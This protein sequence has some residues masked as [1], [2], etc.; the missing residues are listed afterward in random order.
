M[1]KNHYNKKKIYLSFISTISCIINESDKTNINE[2]Y[3]EYSKIYDDLVNIIGKI[4]KYISNFLKTEEST[5][6]T[7]QYL[8]KNCLEKMYKEAKKCYDQLLN[9]NDKNKIHYENIENQKEEVNIAFIN[10]KN[11]IGEVEFIN[12]ISK[13]FLFYNTQSKFIVISK[14]RKYIIEKETNELNYIYRL[15]SKIC[16][17]NKYVEDYFK[18]NKE[19]IY[20]E[21]IKETKNECVK[22]NENDDIIL[23][24][25]F[26]TQQISDFNQLLQNYSNVNEINS[27]YSLDNENSNEEINFLTTFDND[28]S[29]SNR[30]LL[31]SYE[32]FSDKFLDSLMKNEY[33]M[34]NKILH[35][36][37]KTERILIFFNEKLIIFNKYQ[38]DF[39][40]ESENE[41]LFFE[42]VDNCNVKKIDFESRVL[43]FYLDKKK[44]GIIY[45][46][47]NIIE[48]IYTCEIIL[49]KNIN[50]YDNQ[51]IINI[52]SKLFDVKNIG[53]NYFYLFFVKE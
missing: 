2:N 7:F 6:I 53:T 26:E 35:C 51:D 15:T 32:F 48:L 31:I 36:V 21:I 25:E 4:D 8:P 45:I 44:E 41:Y 47:F 11:I 20:Y 10:E 1:K 29:G 12:L 43:F 24:N 38:S 28:Y 50:K 34:F 49:L 5:K 19:K 23:Y 52:N 22:K 18:E 14:E 33:F 9:E 27:N 46:N 13:N 42:N 17:S 40:K 3:L 16:N 39:Q 37:K 30:D